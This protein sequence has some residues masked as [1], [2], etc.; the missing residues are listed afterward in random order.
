MTGTTIHFEGALVRI[1]MARRTRIK[2]Q[3]DV[4]QASLRPTLG[5]VT[6]LASQARVGSAQWKLGLR[7]VET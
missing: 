3:T 4:L 6:L 7:V 1:H 2:G 5:L